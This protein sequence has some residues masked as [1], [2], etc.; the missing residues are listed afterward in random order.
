MHDVLAAVDDRVKETNGDF[1]HY[2]RL[3]RLGREGFDQSELSD[4]SY[5][6]GPVGK[7]DNA[8]W[9][10]DKWKFL[11]MMVRTLEFRPD[12]KWYVFVEPDTYL[13]WSNLL[14]WLQKLD[15]SKP[16]YSGSEVQIGEDIFAHGG[17]AFVMSRSAIQ[18]G[19]E[20]YTSEP[21][22]WH[23]RTSQH[24]AGD[25]I[26]GTAL[27]KAGVGMAWGWPMF[28]GGNPADMNWADAK[29]DRIKLLWCGPA[30][31]YH[32]FDPDQVQD[33]WE[34]EQ[35]WIRNSTAPRSRFWQRRKTVLYH[36]DTFLRYVMPNLT[37]ERAD[38][39]N[40]SPELIPNSR[41]LTAADCR[42]SCEAKTSPANE[43]CVQY[44]LSEIGCSLSSDVK[45]GK[46]AKGVRSGWIMDRVEAWLD[47]LEECG[48]RAGWTVT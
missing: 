12:K 31:S 8:G 27:Q 18:K 34:F 15:P 11:P 39:S 40:S 5:E 37:S 47:G 28:Q 16:F 48:S 3:Q 23:T 29:V 44:A 35:R 21:D 36:S 41:G 7:N 19:A 45:M 9:R 1:A 2:L 10:L 42:A 14:Q 17:S 33:M 32:H 26:L 24:W 46:A 43:T 6:S 38:W 22:E 20:L 25:C 30:I 13:V 4:S